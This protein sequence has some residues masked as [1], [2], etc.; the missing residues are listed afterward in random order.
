MKSYIYS[1]FLLSVACAGLAQ[2][3][4]SGVPAPSGIVCEVLGDSVESY[5]IGILTQDE[6]VGFV[7]VVQL[8]TYDGHSYVANLGRTTWSLTITDS[9]GG[10]VQST[11]SQANTFTRILDEENDVAFD[12]YLSYPP[13]PSF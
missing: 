9:N 4:S 11:S 13:K 7:G 12:C 2:A 5:V 8:G 1:L 10:K 6:Q 3:D